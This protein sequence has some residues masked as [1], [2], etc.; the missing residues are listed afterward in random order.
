MKIL[1]INHYAG[2]PDLGMEFRPYYLAREWVKMGHTVRII[3]ADFSHLRQKNLERK[4]DFALEE[5]DG[6]EYQWV[7][8]GKY[9]GNGIRRAWTML[10]FCGKL[11]ACAG[12][13]ARA[14]RPDVVIASSTY[15]LDNY[16][17][18]RIARKA[19]ARMI[20]EGHDLWPLT[21]TEL[22]GMSKF[23]PF[24]WMMQI[25]E[26]AAY[27]KADAV[28]SLFP[29]AYRHMQAHGLRN[30][31]AFCYIPNGVALQ[32]WAKVDDLPREHDE[33]LLQAKRDACFSVLY[34]GGHALSNA[35][36]VLIETARQ[37]QGEPVRFILIGNG[38]EKPRLMESARGLNNIIFLPPLPKKALIGI[39]AR[40]DALYV[41][42]APCALYQYGVSLNKLYDYMMA[43]RPILYAVQAANNEVEM[44][45]GGITIE[46]GD[47]R[48]LAEAIRTLQQMEP[49]QRDAMGERARTWVM[50]ERRYDL[51]AERFLTVLEDRT[52]DEQRI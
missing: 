37:M 21:L 27:R 7:H 16:P 6:I 29:Y 31:E 39:L 51:L 36:D 1:Y 8:T 5:I 13:L 3:A 41:G 20:F 46:P 26:H 18:R 44:A 11:Y 22:G 40:A 33:A 35:L 43:A 2:S 12:Q 17:A 32:D 52:L 49:S 23:H 34:A 4:V 38:I 14:Y 30:L 42:A 48:A 15:P 10:Q 28:V 47:A 19:G 25:A 24:V 45:G 9:E 50:R